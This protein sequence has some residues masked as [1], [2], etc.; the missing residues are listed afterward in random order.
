MHYN[1][2]SVAVTALKIVEP[3]NIHINVA[4]CAR[5]ENT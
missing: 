5:C 3:L 1:S 2:D 4:L